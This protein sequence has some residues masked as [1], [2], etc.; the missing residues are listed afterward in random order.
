MQH[1]VT[2]PASAAEIVILR[3]LH[4]DDAIDFIAQHDGPKV[5]NAEEV[6]RLRLVYTAP[7]FAAVFPGSAPKLPTLLSDTGI[8]IPEISKKTPKAE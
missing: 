2:K 4:G 1:T 6:A 8:E 3:A 5:S 7:A